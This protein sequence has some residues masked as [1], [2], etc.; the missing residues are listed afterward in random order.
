MKPFT[1]LIQNDQPFG[2]GVEVEVEIEIA[3]NI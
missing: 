1:Y 3:S 2:L